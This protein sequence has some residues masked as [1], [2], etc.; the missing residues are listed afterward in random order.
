[1]VAYF[2]VTKALGM[3]TIFIEQIAVE[4]IIGVYTQERQNKQTLF[5]DLEMQYDASR[6]CESDHIEHAL[7]YHKICLDIHQFVSQSK[8]HLLEALA[9][10]IANRILRDGQVSSVRVSLSKPEALE[11]AHTVRFE[12]TRSNT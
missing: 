11:Q 4:A 8:F 3:E 12:L 9:Q 5:I 6:A 7:D 10:A 2:W 1:M